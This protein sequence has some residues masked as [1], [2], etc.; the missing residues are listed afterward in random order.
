MRKYIVILLSLFL[1]SMCAPP[2]SRLYPVQQKQAEQSKT[3]IR[4]D[5]VF[6]D[7]RFGMSQRQVFAKFRRLVDDSVFALRKS[8]IFEYQMKLDTGTVKV[9]FHTDFYHDSLYAFSIVLRGKD[10]KEAEELQMKMVN[11]VKQKFG[12]PVTIPSESD[13]T[14]MDYYFVN[15]NQQ[16]EIKYPFSSVKVAVTY[17]DW[18]RGNRKMQEELLL[19][20]AEKSKSSK[21]K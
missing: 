12:D 5:T 4:N 19:E 10:Q 18:A 20:K 15:I 1:F 13:K 8:G 16:V 21:K 7:F 6:M 14:K 17:S 3:G 2:K 9:G 11:Q